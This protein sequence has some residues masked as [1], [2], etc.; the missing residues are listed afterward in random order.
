MKREKFKIK[1]RLKSFVYAFNGLLYM[2]KYEHNAR[3]HLFAAICVII[4]GIFFKINA[5]EW[6]AVA[7]AC[8]LVIVTELI[9]SSIEQLAD[10]ISTEENQKIKTGKDLAAAA[11]LFA[12][13]IAVIVG[14][15]IFVPYILKFILP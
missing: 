10:L 1:K 14:L 6:I 3:I 9:N 5:I 4:A 7:F 12:A 2:F 13:I 15:I 11:V 8:G